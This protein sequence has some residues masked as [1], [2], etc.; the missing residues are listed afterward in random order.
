MSERTV[1]QYQIAGGKGVKL[2]FDF[3]PT[4]RDNLRCFREKEP[5]DILRALDLASFL[6]ITVK[7]LLPA[8]HFQNTVTVQQ[9]RKIDPKNKKQFK[10][11]WQPTTANSQNTKGTITEGNVLVTEA[12]KEKINQLKTDW[13]KL[14]HERQDDKV[15]AEGIATNDYKN[16]FVERGT[17]IH[18]TRDFKA[19]NFKEILQKHQV[20]NPERYIDPSPSVGGWNKFIKKQITA[21]QNPKTKRADLFRQ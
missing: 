5:I 15:R 8:K 19:L 11:K 9:Q 13:R 12:K 20:D 21:P 17:I 6:I 4:K 10:H 2:L 16:L 14:W 3:Y 1:N 7:F 18:A